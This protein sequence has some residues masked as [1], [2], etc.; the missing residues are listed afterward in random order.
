MKKVVAVFFYLISISQFCYGSDYKKTIAVVDFIGNNIM[1]T[2]AA[3]FSDFLRAS[4]IMKNF[5]KVLEK[6]VVSEL[7]RRKDFGDEIITTKTAIKL[8][9]LLNVEKIIVGSV[10]RFRK[11]GDYYF[12]TAD[13]IDVKSGKVYISED[14]ETNSKSEFK[15]IAKNIA[16]KITRVLGFEV[17][18]AR[19]SQVKSRKID[20]SRYR[21]LGVGAGYPY[22][23]LIW[24]LF[25]D[26][27]IEPRMAF[28]PGIFTI[29]SRI[30]YRLKKWD[31]Y[32]LY[33]GIEYYHITFDTQQIMGTGS[34]LEVYLGGN[35]H[36]ENKITISLDLGPAYVYLKEKD[37]Y[38]IKSFGDWVVNIGLK[39]FL[40]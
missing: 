19:K 12:I 31:K 40:F 9:K 16:G 7:I 18:L 34:M 5:F 2:E 32:D 27:S 39:Y 26:W 10:S 37:G 17:P 38:F 33:T 4:L 11:L 23:A 6:E 29:G 13:I 21:S 30:N 22:I 20:Y 3:E 24:G 36:M 28:G 25:P 15:Q 14:V 1:Q 8:G 35:Y